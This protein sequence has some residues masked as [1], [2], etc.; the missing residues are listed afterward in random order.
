M[1]DVADDPTNV[2]WSVAQKACAPV[3]VGQVPGEAQQVR[4]R[5]SWSLGH[6]VRGPWR[7]VMVYPAPMG[8]HFVALVSGSP[9]P[10]ACTF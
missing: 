1:A 8:W 4:R 7:V 6:G 5:V 9:L 3:R 10:F 2:I